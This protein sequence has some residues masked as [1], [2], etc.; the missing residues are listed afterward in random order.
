MIIAKINSG[1]Y[2]GQSIQLPPP[3]ITRAVSG[4]VRSAIFNVV[5]VEGCSILDLFAGGGTLGLEALSRGASKVTFVD[6][7]PSAI[8]VIR[9]NV[10]ALGLE[11]EA[12]VVSQSVE[13]FSLN[14][15]KTFDVVF[16]DPPYRDF[17]L[18]LVKTV[19][20][21]V[22]LGGILVVSC[23]IKTNFEVPSEYRDVGQKAYGDTKIIYLQKK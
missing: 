11:R 15:T 12:T 6:K 19:A 7:S 4:K 16:L 23:S 3:S 18:A 21:L 1:A 5:E 8:R 2:R 14:S 13:K 17:S 10:K 22:Q 9:N 20:N